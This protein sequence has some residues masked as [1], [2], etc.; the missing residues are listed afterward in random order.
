MPV[1]GC[2]RGYI[3]PGGLADYS[4]H[5]NCTGTLFCAVSSDLIILQ[6]EQLDTLIK[7]YSVKTI[8]IRIL[9][10]RRC[11]RPEGYAI[12][13]NLKLVFVNIL[14]SMILKDYWVT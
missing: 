2:P 7:W 13:F 4:A 1:P 9:L 10:A 3:G 5:P 6:E 8:C 11:T 14:R 12:K